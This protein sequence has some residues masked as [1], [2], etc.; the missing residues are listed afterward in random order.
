MLCV[1]VASC[2]QLPSLLLAS[3]IPRL[4][5]TQ[6]KNSVT[7]SWAG[8][9]ERGYLLAAQLRFLGSN[10]DCKK[11]VCSTSLKHSCCDVSAAIH[12]RKVLLLTNKS[13]G[14]VIVFKV[15][16]A[17]LIITVRLHFARA[18]G[19]HIFKLNPGK[20]TVCLLKRF[21]VKVKVGLGSQFS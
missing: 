17:R 9:W 6:T 5:H 18:V 13:Q 15:L 3:L 20:I 11:S 14:V 10:C 2:V 12:M 8:A 4:S 19:G 21:R 1:F 7:K 16:Q